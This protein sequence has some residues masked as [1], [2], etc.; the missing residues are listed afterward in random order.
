MS[1]DTN[2]KMDNHSCSSIQVIFITIEVFYEENIHINNKK[3]KSKIIKVELSDFNSNTNMLSHTLN[4]SH[5]TLLVEG[6]VAVK[7]SK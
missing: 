3:I 7:K 1:V 6:L 4:S 5:T 2:H